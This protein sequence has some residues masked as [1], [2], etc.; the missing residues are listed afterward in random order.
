[1]GVAPLHTDDDGLVHLIGNHFADALF[2]QIAMCLIGR[3][4]RHI[5]KK[6][7]FTSELRH[8][9]FDPRDVPTQCAQQSRLFK[10]GAGLLQPQIEQFAPQVLTLGLE[11]L[12]SKIAKFR[13]FHFKSISCDV[14]QI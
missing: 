11:F 14:S 10:P 12:R 2:A 6:S 3:F 5:N 9:S 13:K 8:F 4:F 7:G 1:M